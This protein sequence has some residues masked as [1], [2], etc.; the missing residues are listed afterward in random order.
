MLTL[1]VINTISLLILLLYNTMECASNYY[2]LI[3]CKLFIVLIRALKLQF[4]STIAK[5]S[6]ENINPFGDEVNANLFPHWSKTCDARLPRSGGIPY[7][8]KV[9]LRDLSLNVASQSKTSG[10]AYSNIMICEKS[11]AEVLFF[12]PNKFCTCL[13]RKTNYQTKTKTINW[14][15]AFRK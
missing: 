7:I 6:T 1:T 4:L 8:F 13:A 11:V 9:P 14:T 2:V 3:H 10:S 12:W 15:Y 5:I